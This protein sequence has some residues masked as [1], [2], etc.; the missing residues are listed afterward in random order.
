MVGIRNGLEG[1]SRDVF[2]HRARLSYRRQGV[3]TAHKMEIFQMQQS[4]KSVAYTT[5]AGFLLL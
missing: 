4:D 1:A 2:G 3:Q 5:P